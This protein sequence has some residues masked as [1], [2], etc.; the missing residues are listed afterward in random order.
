MNSKITTFLLIAGIFS[1][2]SCGKKKYP[3][4]PRLEYKSVSKQS[5]SQNGQDS[6]VLTFSYTD[7][8]GDIGSEILDNIFVRDAR[9]NQILA[10]YRF[11]NEVEA[12]EGAYRKGE[13]QLIIY[14][15]CCIYNDTS[16]VACF[17]NANQPLD[18]MRY[19]VEVLDQAGHLINVIESDDIFLDCN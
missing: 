18:T 14:S 5:M 6:L 3:I 2:I 4:E 16:Y 10:S 9:N 17:P 11:P 8:D 15:G 19:T 12:E 13:L 1:I 7:G